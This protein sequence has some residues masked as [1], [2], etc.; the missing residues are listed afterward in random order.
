MASSKLVAE[1]TQRL[2]F[3]ITKNGVAWNL[4][5]ATVTV[6]FGKEGGDGPTPFTRAATPLTDG[7]DGVMYYDTTTTDFLAIYEGNWR[8][9]VR[10]VQSS[11]DEK[12]EY[13]SFNLK[14]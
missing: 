13:Q 9:K 6:T 10:V 4:A 11:I 12:S 14:P 8:L 2:L 5:G 7:T 1:S 3:P